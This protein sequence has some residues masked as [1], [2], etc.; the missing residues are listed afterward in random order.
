[1]VTWE[2]VRFVALLIPTWVL[3]GAVAVSLA[4]PAKGRAAADEDRTQIIAA[5][6][7][8]SD[9]SALQVPAGGAGG[10]A[11]KYA[12]YSAGGAEE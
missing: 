7:L 2:H 4:L 8:N 6:C 3:L 10:A 12:G 11:D 1:M 9:D 5:S